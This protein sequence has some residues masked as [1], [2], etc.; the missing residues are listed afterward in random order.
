MKIHSVAAAKTSVAPLTQSSD[1]LQR[2]EY[3][4]RSPDFIVSPHSRWGDI[5]WRF[6]SLSAG[7]R[8]P[9]VKWQFTL[10][11]G[12]GSTDD[13]YRPLLESFKEVLYA[14]ITRESSWGIVLSAASCGRMM[15]G[16][17][18]LFS[19][20]VFNGFYSLDALS[21]DV[22]ERYLAD[23]PYILSNKALFYHV[24]ASRVV[25]DFFDDS[26]FPDP[27]GNLEMNESGSVH[28]PEFEDGIDALEDDDSG[29]ER[30]YSY[31][32]ASLRVNI[33][34][35]IQAQRSVLRLRG[36]PFFDGPAFR[37]AAS[38][39][40]TA[41]LAKYVVNRLPPLPD[42]VLLPIVN[43][44]MVWVE[45]RVDDIVNLQGIYLARK[46]EISRNPSLKHK[47]NRAL[48]AELAAFEFS[49]A[50]RS[51]LPW[52]SHLTGEYVVTHDYGEVYLGPIQQLR[53]LVCRLRDACMILLSF[54]VGLRTGELCAIQVTKA[55]GEL[56]SCVT[57]RLNSTGTLELFFVK[58]VLTKG[59]TSPRE[60]EWLL[61]CRPS[62]AT[63]LPLAVRVIQV[64]E[65]L[66]APWRELAGSDR[67]FL[68]FSQTQGF[69]SNGASVSNL[70]ADT[71]N[72]GIKLFIHGE[73]DLTDLPDT[74]ERGEQLWMYRD[75]HGLI[76]RNLHW[77]K[78]FAAYILESRNALIPS[79]KQHFKHMKDAITESAYFPTVHR[80]RQDTDSAQAAESISWLAHVLDGT[81]LLGSMAKTID[82]WRNSEGMRSLSPADR[83][84][85][86]RQVVM[87]H[88]IR[89]FF[90]DHVN[91]L[92]QAN[93]LASRC[94]QATGSQSWAVDSPDYSVRNPSMCAGC[95]CGVIDLS[96]LPFWRARLAEYEDALSHVPHQQLG[97]FRVAAFRR[98]Q[99]SQVIKM[100]ERRHQ[101]HEHGQ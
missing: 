2:G 5:T 37:G 77:R 69:P 85:A 13:L 42:E 82:D 21:E 44:A 29:G 84:A 72:A 50:R 34:Y 70:L 49:V 26:S 73:V 65:R 16:I 55:D 63:V 6:D 81:P 92:I 30:G 80:L 3:K 31:G 56:P 97:E 62:G 74:N 66:W 1:E 36:L 11:N 9:K 53:N 95:G 78:S 28:T 48:S 14:M 57:N 24:D 40:I 38:Y 43:E 91:C 18:E 93:P 68:N 15:V 12:V 90:S 67:L 61:G 71:A 83:E 99:A 89:V 88:D 35:Y 47:I 59:V 22:Q 86:V 8:D 60:E 96:H 17:R 76:I 87:T 32:A 79:V 25:D 64:V 94:R 54:L 101:E 100:M 10:I 46:Q 23:L 41:Q 27:G 75:S 7:S 33:I 58:S 39:E 98:E 20:L 45:E 51:G 52:R 19:W 4:F